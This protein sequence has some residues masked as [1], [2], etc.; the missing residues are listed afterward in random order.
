ML[1]ILARLRKPE[2]KKKT[3]NDFVVIDKM[4]L[5]SEQDKQQSVIGFRNNIYI[6]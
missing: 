1:S 3:C 4:Y 6:L 2:I 5:S